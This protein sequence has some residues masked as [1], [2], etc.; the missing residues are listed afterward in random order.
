ME[1][2]KLLEMLKSNMIE[3]EGKYKEVDAKMQALVDQSKQL[4][5]TYNNYA[6]SKE[7]L[8]GEYTAIFN[9]YTKLTTNKDDV[10]E[11]TQPNPAVSEKKTAKKKNEKQTN[12]ELTAE[13]ISTIK[14]LNNKEKEAKKE[15]IPDYLLDQYKK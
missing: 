5:E 8:R 4:Q 10:K 6:M 9:L 15:D 1:Q 7:Q 12:S 14:A 13:E 3:I 11:E 2:E